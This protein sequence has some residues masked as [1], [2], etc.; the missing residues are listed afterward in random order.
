MSLKPEFFADLDR[1]H[2]YARELVFCSLMNENTGKAVWNYI[3]GQRYSFDGT[4]PPSWGR[5]V[6]SQGVKF[7][8]NREHINAPVL[9]TILPAGSEITIL[10]GY[11]HLTSPSYNYFFSTETYTN[12]SLFINVSSD[13]LRVHCG[14][15]QLLSETVVDFHL[16]RVIGLTITSGGFATVYKDGLSVA[17]G[18]STALGD[19]AETFNIGGRS[20]SDNRYAGGIIEWF[21]IGNKV[22]SDA[23]IFDI[24]HDSFAMFKKFFPSFM[25]IAAGGISIPIVMAQ[26][27]QFSGGSL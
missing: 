3:N 21:Y 26:Y 24:S 13:N 11:K 5:A 17:S 14:G 25:Y 8:A 6:D 7:D 15:T 16:G 23:T 10:F 4:Y 9:N 20:D 27:G 1:G 19:H 22:L 12:L 2:P 18:G